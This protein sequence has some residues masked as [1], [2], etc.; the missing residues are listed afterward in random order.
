MTR[1]R[2]DNPLKN[3]DVSTNETNVKVGEDCCPLCEVNLTNKK[4]LQESDKCCIRIA[5][6]MED[7]RSGF[8][9]RDSYGYGIAGLLYHINRENDKEFK[10]LSSQ[11]PLSGP[12]FKR[13]TTTLVILE[14]GKHTP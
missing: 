10:A 2:N 4:A 5:Q 14:L 11:K 6:L 12:S 13:C 9:K 3:E 1:K 8:H 7:P